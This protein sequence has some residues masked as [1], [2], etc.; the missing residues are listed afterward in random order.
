M[1]K[2]TLVIVCALLAVIVA[3]LVY[4]G[5]T[6]G[7]SRQSVDKPSQ[8]TSVETPVNAPQP[9]SAGV[10]TS[11]DAS[12]VASTEGDILLFFH[13]S[14]CPQC[15]AIEQSIYDNGLPSGVTV[16]KVD[17]DTNQ[18]LRQQYGVTLQT[19]FVKVNRQGEKLASY[20]AYNEPTF[21]AVKRE[22]LP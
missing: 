6:R 4:V 20:V 11:Y 16:Y 2:K 21:S 18:A 8:P 10:Y 22:L 9:A 1:N 17:Y 7:Q 14:W 12:K 5:V 19:T 3:A 15:R 13:A